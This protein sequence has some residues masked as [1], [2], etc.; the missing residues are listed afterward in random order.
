MY[1]Y[2]HTHTH[3]YIYMYTH[4]PRASIKHTAEG[5]TLCRPQL[6]GERAAVSSKSG[7]EPTFEKIYF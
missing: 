3:I 4:T 6:V 2:T 5:T 1:I 7:N